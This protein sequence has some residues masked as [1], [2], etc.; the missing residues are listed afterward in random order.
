MVSPRLVPVVQSLI[1]TGLF[2]DAMTSGAITPLLPYLVVR[3]R[4]SEQTVANLLAVG[5]GATLAAMLPSTILLL[6]TGHLPMLAMGLVALLVS[7]ALLGLNYSLWQLYGAMVL[8]GVSSEFIFAAALAMVTKLHKSGGAAQAEASQGGGEETAEEG[9]QA[10]PPWQVLQLALSPRALSPRALLANYGFIG[11]EMGGA[12]EVSNLLRSLSFTLG[13]SDILRTATVGPVSG[14]YTGGQFA[15]GGSAG[16]ALSAPASPRSPS[17][18]DRRHTSPVLPKPPEK[19]SVPVTL[20]LVGPKPTFGGIPAANTSLV[21]VPLRVEQRL[22]STVVEPSE[23]ARSG[24]ERPDC[25]PETGSQEQER[26]TQKEKQD[27]TPSASGSTGLVQGVGLLFAAQ[28]M[29]YV[30]GPFIVPILYGLVDAW[31][32]FLIIGLMTAAILALIL[33]LSS[34]RVERWVACWTGDAGKETGDSGRGTEEDILRAPDACERVGDGSDQSASIQVAGAGDKQDV[35]VD[36]SHLDDRDVTEVVGSSRER[37]VGDVDETSAGEMLGGLK[38]RSEKILGLS[39]LRGSFGSKEVDTNVRERVEKEERSTGVEGNREVQVRACVEGPATGGCAES[40]EKLNGGEVSREC[41]DTPGK[42]AAPALTPAA[43]Q[44][45]RRKREKH[46]TQRVLPES[47]HEEKG[48]PG[49]ESSSTRQRRDSGSFR[50]SNSSFPRGSD[51]DSSPSPLVELSEAL[52]DPHLLCRLREAESATESKPGFSSQASNGALAGTNPSPKPGAKGRTPSVLRSVAGLLLSAHAFPAILVVFAEAVVMGAVDTVIPLFL[53]DTCHVSAAESGLI[54]GAL[55]L[56]YAGAAYWLTTW[57]VGRVGDI[58][59]MVLG[60]VAM[61]VVMPVM[62]MRELCALWAQM[63][64]II[65]IGFGM[66]LMGGPTFPR[67]VGALNLRG[68]QDDGV[69]VIFYDALYSGGMIVGP[70]I[71]LSLKNA[72]SSATVLQI[73]SGFLALVVGAIY[74]VEFLSRG[75]GTESEKGG[76]KRQ[77]STSAPEEANAE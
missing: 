60:A 1:S 41:Q 58:H 75:R 48:S 22:S 28:S 47:Y 72:T 17:E 76:I 24:T 57:L 51:V 56:A 10:A 63:L 61:G 53:L 4:G 52:P 45:S 50:D 73:L 30:F 20:S 9:A 68:S 14:K 74:V 16:V 54:F 77:S 15:R 25:A 32:P 12:A 21:L 59:T 67:L 44:S 3:F 34:D 6:N 26:E 13:R 31:L 66:A 35:N 33:L 62:A 18:L 38:G 8:T 23:S 37:Q 27:R 29:G 55:A 39:K 65:P 19:P 2:L 49:V 36:V 43:I 42:S 11:R 7:C 5:Y 46:V 71:G 40:N 69:A 64:V 70:F